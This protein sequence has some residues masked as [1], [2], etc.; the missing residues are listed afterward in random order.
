M[1]PASAPKSVTETELLGWGVGS[2]TAWKSTRSMTVH[3]AFESAGTLRRTTSPAWYTLGRSTRCS[4]EKC[5][6]LKGLGPVGVGV[7]KAGAP[8]DAGVTEC[9]ARGS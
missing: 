9:G 3:V 5:M 2:S 8:E 6:G 4:S 1:P 7:V